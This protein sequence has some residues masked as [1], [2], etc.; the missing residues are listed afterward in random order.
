LQQVW[1]QELQVLQQ[2][3]QQLLQQ[4]LQLLQQVLQPLLQ[5][6]T[7]FSTHFLTMQHTGQSTQ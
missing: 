1:Q 2:V 5:Q 3:L 4:E 6:G 7:R